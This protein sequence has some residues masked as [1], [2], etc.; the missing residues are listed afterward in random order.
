MQATKLKFDIVNYMVS[1]LII[2]IYFVISV[3]I[4]CLVY[5][6]YVSYVLLFLQL[7]VDSAH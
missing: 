2:Y 5:Y 6:P 3:S 4:I 1:Q 7:A